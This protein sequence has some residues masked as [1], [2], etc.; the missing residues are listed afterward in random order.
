MSRSRKSAPENL[1]AIATN[2]NIGLQSIG[3]ILHQLTT[4]IQLKDFT[5]VGLLH[6]HNCFIAQKLTIFLS[7][8]T[9]TE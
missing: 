1:R 7:Q 3:T 4:A 5:N 9:M 2:P 8:T 6:V